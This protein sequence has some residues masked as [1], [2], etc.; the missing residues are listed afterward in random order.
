M[1]KGEQMMRMKRLRMVHGYLYIAPWLIGFFLLTLYPFMMSLF[2]S[3][4]DFDMFSYEWVGL[5]N[6]IK[7]F[8]GDR[9]CLSIRF[10]VRFYTRRSRYP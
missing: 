1:V 7:I 8:T 3:F 5:S 10:R 9:V 6:Y 4:T 2:Y